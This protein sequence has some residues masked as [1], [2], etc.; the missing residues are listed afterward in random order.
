VGR[1]FVNRFS[2]DYES[3]G[4]MDGESSE[5]EKDEPTSVFE[6]EQQR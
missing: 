3:E 5:D 4:V 1:I 6:S 2:L